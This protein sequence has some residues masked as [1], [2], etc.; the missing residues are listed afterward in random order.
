MFLASDSDPDLAYE[1]LLAEQVLEALSLAGRDAGSVELYAGIAP[2]PGFEF[3]RRYLRPDGRVVTTMASDDLT[4]LPPCAEIDREVPFW[5]FRSSSGEPVGLVLP[6]CAG[7]YRHNHRAQG[8][9]A[10]YCVRGYHPPII[11][12]VSRS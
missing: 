2:A 7:D 6:R 8:H 3:S 1:D 5:L 11:A 4:G 12:C 10:S 9:E